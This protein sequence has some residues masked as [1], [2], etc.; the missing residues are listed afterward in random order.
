MPLGIESMKK[1]TIALVGTICILLI[2]TYVSKS[3]GR[4]LSE[5]VGIEPLEHHISIDN[6]YFSGIG[7]DHYYLWEISMPNVSSFENRLIK[8]G[9]Q[10]GE[11]NNSGCLYLSENSHPDWWN[12]DDQI[13]KNYKLYLNDK[14]QGGS[15]CIYISKTKP[16]AYLMWFD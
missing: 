13:T 11:I 15:T 5:K 9:L 4:M 7:M 8:I 6:Y 10:S 1:F 3:S 12:S 14:A 16:I 2:F